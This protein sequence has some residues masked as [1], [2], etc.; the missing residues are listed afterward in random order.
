VNRR[1]LLKALAACSGS[2]LLEG[3]APKRVRSSLNSAPVNQLHL[4]KVLVSADREIRTTVCLRPFRAPGFRLATEKLD[5]KLCV[6]NY[7]HGGAGITLSWGTAQL[8]TE[9][10][11]NSGQ[12]RV[13]VLGC[14]VIGLATARLLQQLGKDVTIYTKGLPPETTSNSAGGLWLPY[15]L[16]DPDRET[17]QFHQQFL[18]SVKFSYT[19][20]QQFAGEDYSVRWMPIYVVTDEAFSETEMLAPKGP[21]PEVFPE[22]RDLQPS[23]HLFPYRYVRQFRAMLIEPYPYLRA[24]LR[25]FRLVGGR[26]VLQEF[27]DIAEITTLPEPVVVNCSGLGS[28]VLFSDTELIP[29]K[30]QLTLLLPQPEVNYIVLAGG[31]YMFP[32][33][34]GIVL[35]GTHVRGDWSLEPDL[36]A[37]SQILAGHSRLFSRL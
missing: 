21:F 15:S 37:K 30:G 33:R 34:D 35:G 2:L 24:L 12:K 25:D 32:R 19:Y 27:H 18:Q 5:D 7:G 29:I 26:V 16:F 28:R 4:P 17:P 11:R 13:A 36:A 10:V 22:L 20:F 14:G 3:C 1:T 8:A 6:H 23:E 9:N 31:L